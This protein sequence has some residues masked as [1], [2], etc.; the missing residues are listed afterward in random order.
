IDYF[1][2]RQ[3]SKLNKEPNRQQVNRQQ[4]NRQ[5][6]AAPP[7]P[8][9]PPRQPPTLPSTNLD[10]RLDFKVARILN[11]PSPRNQSQQTYIPP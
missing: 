4:T 3:R 1:I 2:E 10:D 7:P 6:L 11:E 9:P 8:L 5:R